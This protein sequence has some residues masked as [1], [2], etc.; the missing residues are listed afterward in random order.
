[1]IK[2]KLNFS[3]ND[4][5]DVLSLCESDISLLCPKLMNYGEYWTHSEITFE[6]LHYPWI[7]FKMITI[8]TIKRVM[9]LM[10]TR[11]SL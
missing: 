11:A 4:H 6:T 2:V 1:M 5:I 9:I 8:P 10:M 7:S 3:W